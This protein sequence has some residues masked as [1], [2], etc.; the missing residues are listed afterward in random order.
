[1]NG[2]LSVCKFSHLMFMQ[3]AC[4]VVK[5]KSSDQMELRDVQCYQLV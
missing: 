2:M 3:Q 1:M 4:K 5:L